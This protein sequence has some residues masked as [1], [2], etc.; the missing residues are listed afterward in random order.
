MLVFGLLRKVI[1]AHR[2]THLRRFILRLANR[3]QPLMLKTQVAVEVRK[4]IL[5][6]R[7][8]GYL[9]ARPQPAHRHVFFAIIGFGSPLL[10][11][12]SF[13]QLGRVDSL[14]RTTE[15]AKLEEFGNTVELGCTLDE[16]GLEGGWAEG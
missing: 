12:V 16:T 2:T 4:I 10:L 13:G 6:I 3:Q 8:V 11:S 7:F 1:R 15:L 14:P 9:C 5:R